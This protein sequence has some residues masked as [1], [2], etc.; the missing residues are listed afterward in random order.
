MNTLETL[1][2]KLQAIAEKNDDEFQYRIDITKT[3]TGLNLV[4]VCEETADGHVFLSG[5][6]TSVEEAVAHAAK[7]VDSSVEEWS[8]EPAGTILGAKI[9][10][11]KTC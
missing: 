3:R 11:Q 6:G 4:F 5:R 8:Y 2:E 9:I 10:S 7:G 1:I